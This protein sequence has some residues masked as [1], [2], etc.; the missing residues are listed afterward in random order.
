MATAQ[1]M[2]PLSEQHHKFL[3]CPHLCTVLCTHAFTSCFLMLSLVLSH[4]LPLHIFFKTMGTVVIEST[5][6]G[7]I[8]VIDHHLIPF[9]FYIQLQTAK[10]H[11]FLFFPN[12]SLNFVYLNG[13]IFSQFH[14]FS[15]FLDENLGTAKIIDSVH[16]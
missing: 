12:K 14:I 1:I 3:L 13:I 8:T 10:A 15:V 7:E 6:T 4:P 16:P 11:M 9:Q 2:Q 5:P